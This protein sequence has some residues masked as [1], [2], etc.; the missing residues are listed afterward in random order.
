[1]ALRS[2]D[3]MALDETVIEDPELE[4][5]LE[6]REKKKAAASIARSIFKEADDAAKGEIRKHGEID[7]I[8]ALRVGRYRITRKET[9]AR[10]VS[11][12][13]EAK[14]RIAIELVDDE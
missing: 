11:F 1:M 10:A 5:L 6:D 3:Q 2:V 13:T 9:P 8:G 4:A 7:D 12:E 14:S